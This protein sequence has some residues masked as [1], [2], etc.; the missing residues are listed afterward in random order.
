MTILS[1]N[2]P[3]D[4]KM[5]LLHLYPTNLKL[6]TRECKFIDFAIL[7]AKRLIALN[8]KKISAPTI[9][10]WINTMAQCMSMER[11]TYILKNKLDVYEGIWRPF[12]DFMNH[13]DI[14]ALLQEEDSG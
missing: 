14:G 10:A 11:I 9:G 3:V 8:W 13:R 7:Q 1:I 5:I 4:S 12:K 2:I 6:R